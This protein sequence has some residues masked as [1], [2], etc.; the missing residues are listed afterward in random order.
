ME[1]VFIRQIQFN[2]IEVV[3]ISG[4]AVTVIS[5]F[6]A[7]VFLKKY[8]TEIKKM[9]MVLNVFL[10]IITL[11]G[12]ILNVFNEYFNNLFNNFSSIALYIL[13]ANIL[14]QGFWWKWLR[15]NFIYS[16]I[17]FICINIFNILPFF[18]RK[19]VFDWIMPLPSE[20]VQFWSVINHITKKIEFVFLL[21]VVF[22]ILFS[23]I[24]I[25]INRIFLNN[26]NKLKY[27]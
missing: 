2:F 8:R 27:L 17:T 3:I 13:I 21:G 1:E 10:A 11:P 22:A 4:Y 5:Y 18:G 23:G 16:T 24:Y 7:W 6:L 15:K 25:F 14:P 19:V 9:L 26:K 12:L 20:N